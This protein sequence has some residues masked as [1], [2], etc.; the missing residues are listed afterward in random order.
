MQFTCLMNFLCL[1]NEFHK[2]VFHK[3]DKDFT[4]YEIIK[5]ELKL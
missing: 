1:F 3:M 4:F 2:G 5:M